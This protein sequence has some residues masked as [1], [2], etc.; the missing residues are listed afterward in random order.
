MAITEENGLDCRDDTGGGVSSRERLILNCE[1]KSPFDRVPT[2]RREREVV[3]GGV[4]SC[5]VSYDHN[6]VDR[7]M[8]L[9][10][11]PLFEVRS[12]GPHIDL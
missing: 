1:A 11:G 2:A 12:T 4:V 8:A 10:I 9:S 5:V 7:H 6:R 3:D